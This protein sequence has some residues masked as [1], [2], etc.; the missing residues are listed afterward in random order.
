MEHASSFDRPLPWRTATAVLAVVATVELVGLLALAGVRLIPSLHPA[1]RATAPAASV[2]A[3]HP[4]T[5]ARVH[6]LRVAPAHALRPVSQVSVLVLNGNGRTGAAGS[7][8][9]RIIGAGYRHATPADAPNHD[10]AHSIV[11]FAPG[12]E[13]EGKRL[14]RKL[15][16]GIVGPLDG[17]RP[18]QLKGSQLVVILGDS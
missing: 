17:M 16:V 18:S 12:Y 13:L 3:A 5:V 8:A 9:Q 2:P 6:P 1:A 14:A 7:E 10:Y 4:P 11:L 15:R